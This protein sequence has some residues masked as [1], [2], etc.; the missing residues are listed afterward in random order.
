MSRS[1]VVTVTPREGY[2]VPGSLAIP[3]EPAPGE[4]GPGPRSTA[5]HA[6]RSLCR[7]ARVDSLGVRALVAPVL[8]AASSEGSYEGQVPSS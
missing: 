3:G 2:E 4:G 8:P 5:P 1:T 6:Q 7:R